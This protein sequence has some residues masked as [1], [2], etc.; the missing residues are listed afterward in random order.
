MDHDVDAFVAGVGSG[1][2]LTGIGRYLREQDPSIELILADPKGSILAP[3]INEGRDVEA[4]SWLVEGVG[5]DFVPN[6]ADID[7]ATRAITV[8]DA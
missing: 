7:L 1:G 6:I 5:E 8:D 3:K 4:G 2:T